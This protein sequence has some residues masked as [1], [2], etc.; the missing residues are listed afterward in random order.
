MDLN[1]PGAIELHIDKL[2]LHGLPP[3]GRYR[4]ADA[5]QAELGRLLTERGVSP[6]RAGDAQVAR[7]DAGSFDVPPGSTAVGIGTAVAR[8]LHGALTR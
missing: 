4:I 6:S 2:V 8:K 3:G 1:T 7:V 5:L